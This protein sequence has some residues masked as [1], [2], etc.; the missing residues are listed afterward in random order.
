MA[1]EAFCSGDRLA[2]NVMF[3]MLALIVPGI[4]YNESREVKIAQDL[5]S[6]L[7]SVV[8]VSSESVSKEN[9]GKLIHVAGPISDVSEITLEDEA[10]AVSVKGSVKLK[11]LVEML[12]WKEIQ[13]KRRKKV[14]KKDTKD[15]TRFSYIQV[16]S[17]KYINS[18]Q[19]QDPSYRNPPFLPEL[20]TRDFLP[21]KVKIGAYEVPQKLLSVSL[22]THN[23]VPIDEEVIASLK[24]GVQGSGDG[25]LNGGGQKRKSKSVRGAISKVRAIFMKTGPLQIND[26]K[27]YSGKE[28]SKDVGSYRVSFWSSG[29]SY[30]S[31]LGKQSGESISPFTASNGNKLYMLKAG[32][33]SADDM[34]SEDE[35][36]DSSISWLFRLIFLLLLIPSTNFY[37]NAMYGKATYTRLQS[38]AADA[39]VVDNN[40]KVPIREVSLAVS[41]IL[42]L[43]VCGTVWLGTR[44]WLGVTLYALAVALAVYVFKFS[45]AF[46]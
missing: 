19:F 14:S 1:K 35:N 22:P 29:H 25:I 9:D 30:L 32:L 23:V 34:L 28:D 3:I 2:T 16:W 40:L 10:F 43:F 8:S 41:L 6:K 5:D 17:D 44:I 15:T 46:N 18:K 42:Y 39:P 27:L 36:Y 38:D 12:Q 33:H 24:S 21:S 11:R 7:K 20:K 45:G 31:V 26:N 4:I 37:L 13:T